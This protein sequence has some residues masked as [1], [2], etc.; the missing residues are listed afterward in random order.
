MKKVIFI[1]ILF[2]F[3]TTAFKLI[4]NAKDNSQQWSKINDYIYINKDSI[5]K[6]NDTVS[7]WFKIYSSPD[8]ELHEIN[9]MPINYEIIQYEVECTNPTTISIAHSKSYSKNNNLIDEYINEQ[10]YAC[11]CPCIVNDDIYV[12]ELCVI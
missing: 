10:G 9:N 3:L 5:T 7:A 2:L 8:N 11:S 4:S 1:F 12:K 6:N